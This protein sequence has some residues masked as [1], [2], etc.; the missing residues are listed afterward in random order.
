MPNRCKMAVPAVLA[1]GLLTLHGA[2]EA[3]AARIVCEGNVQVAKGQAL[4][5]PICRD[6]NLARVA[7]SYGIRV[8][9]RKIRTSEST[10]AEVCRAIG[11]DNR[12]EEACAPY[13]TGRSLE[14]RTK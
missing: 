7:R 13:L 1:F 11:F 8:T 6:R 2:G 9:E 10:K 3:R 14:H 4:P 12:V 5:S